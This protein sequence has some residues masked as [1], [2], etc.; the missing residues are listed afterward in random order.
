M[1]DEQSHDLIRFVT[2]PSP[3]PYLPAESAQL[4]YRVPATLD[5]ESL[6][7]LLERGWRRFGNYVFRPQCQACQKCRPLRIILDDFRPSK[8]QRKALRRNQHV[9]VSVTQP[10]VTDEH[11]ALF[12][13]YHRDMADRRDW[14]DNATS[15]QNY[16]ESFIGR[17]FEFAREFQ[18]REDGRLIG[19][20]IVDVL[21][22]SLSSAYF[23][24]DP[25]WRKLSPGTFSILTEIEWAQANSLKYSYLGYWIH[26]NQSMDYKARFV[27]HQLLEACVDVDEQPIWKL[28]AD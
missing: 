9:E 24:H 16:Y 28:A 26:E 23:Y 13:L 1:P 21:N 2:E 3:C 25:A 8:S 17:P 5:A 22:D 10:H 11:V 4:E 12:N 7:R 14:P 18:Y 27:P 6:E 15:F 20:G 19:V